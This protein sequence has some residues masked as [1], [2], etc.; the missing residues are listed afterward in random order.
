MQFVETVFAEL[1]CVSMTSY[2]EKG[3]SYL[4]KNL[5][6]QRGRSHCV[7]LNIYDPEPDNEIKLLNAFF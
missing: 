5:A 2:G 3:S 6:W 4:L 1:D 7:T